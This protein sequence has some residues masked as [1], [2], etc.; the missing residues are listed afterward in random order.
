MSSMKFPVPPGAGTAVV[1]STPSLPGGGIFVGWERVDPEDSEEGLTPNARRGA[2]GA[3]Q[4]AAPLNA[5][6]SRNADALLEYCGLRVF[7]F[8]SDGVSN[9]EKVQRNISGT[10][11]RGNVAV[12]TVATSGRCICRSEAGRRWRRWQNRTRRKR[13]PSPR[14]CGV[15]RE[16]P[17]ASVRPREW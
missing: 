13:R 2:L 6:Q 12:V 3:I 1:T 8:L 5:V 17:E 10:S 15:R 16:F 14:R 9:Q 11:R 4:R 7:P